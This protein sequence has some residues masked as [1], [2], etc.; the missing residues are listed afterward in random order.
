[1]TIRA[2]IHHVTSYRYDRLVG[3]S[4]QVIRLRP[5]PHCR[6]PIV[7]Y[8]LQISPEPHFLNWQQDPQS[9]WLAR[10]VF[11]EQTDH[12]TGPQLKAEI[13]HHLATAI[14]LCQP[15]A[16]QS[17]TGLRHCEAPAS[18]AAPS[19]AASA[20]GSMRKRTR[21]PPSPP[22]SSCPLSTR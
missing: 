19:A 5:A 1:M 10:V 2:A 7:S 6:T 15:L 3:L 22:A 18:V 13:V 4:P 16:S 11:P 8:S 17:P 9:N 12:F 14:G 20:F 21:P